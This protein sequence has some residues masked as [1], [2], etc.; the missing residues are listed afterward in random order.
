[1]EQN[2]VLSGRIL[3]KF[4]IFPLGR[5]CQKIS[6]EKNID[7]YLEES[8]GVDKRTFTNGMITLLLVSSL[9][10]GIALQRSGNSLI[11]IFLIIT[12]LFL[13]LIKIVDHV[14][15]SS[16]ELQRTR[17]DITTILVL[18]DIWAVW[19]VTGSIF[20]LIQ[21]IAQGNYP[22]LLE[23]WQTLPTDINLGENPEKTIRMFFK[24]NQY[25]ELD[26]VITVLLHRTTP[27]EAI[28]L[29]IEEL[30]NDSHACY[31]AGLSKL[32][33]LASLMMGANSILPISLSLL[34]LIAGLGNTPAILIVPIL[35][36]FLTAIILRLG[37]YP[38]LVDLSQDTIIQENEIGWFLINFG[39]QLEKIDCQ[40]I[41]LVELLAEE[42]STFKISSGTM[43]DIVYNLES[44]PLI[45]KIFRNIPTLL[46]TAKLCDNFLTLDVRTAATSIKKLGVTLNENIS[47]KKKIQNAINAE[48]SRI[49]V[50]QSVTAVILGLLAAI[51]PLFSLIG[52]V[53]DF[54]SLS[55]LFPPVNTPWWILIA[56]GSIILIGG[57]YMLRQRSDKKLDAIQILLNLVLFFITYRIGIGFIAQLY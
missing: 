34:F 31:L 7:M 17:R 42:N 3:K 53:R 23:K 20:D 33:D 18:N 22:D 4:S 26:H 9:A 56:M 16:Y 46:H 35:A 28:S 30:K 25:S 11:N 32:S 21:Y 13:F 52:K 54:G 10:V 2:M 48:K 55:P 14:V 44:T 51:A 49:K 47:I 12:A 40:E 45:E 41:A 15:H 57:A 19:E 5:L 29:K 24:E 37:F 6:Q 39:R 27:D 1:M 38:F 50:I 8:F 43:A 36:M